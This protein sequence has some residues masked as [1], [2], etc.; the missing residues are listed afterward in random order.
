EMDALIKRAIEE[1]Y[2][3]GITGKEVTPWLLGRIVELSDG[4]S[5]ITNQALITNNASLSGE[6]A[7]QLAIH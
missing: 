7:V 4:R 2:Q 1:S 6:L 3:A 5:L